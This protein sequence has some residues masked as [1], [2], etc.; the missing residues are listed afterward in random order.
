MAPVYTSHLVRLKQRLDAKHK[1]HQA[2]TKEEQ[3]QSSKDA[4]KKAHE[5]QADMEKEWIRQDL[6]A[7]T[8]AIKYGKKLIWMSSRLQQ[9]STLKHNQRAVNKWNA[10]VHVQSLEINEGSDFLT[11]IYQSNSC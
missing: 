11:L 10:L 7:S 2:M 6:A 1:S 4:R 8:L 5:L 3:S 9:L